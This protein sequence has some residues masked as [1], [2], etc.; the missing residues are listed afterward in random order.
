ELYFGNINPNEKQFVQ[1]S[2]YSK[3]MQTIFTNEGKLTELLTG[4]E[5]SLF[6]DYA[7]AQSEINSITAIEYFSDGFRL[8]AKIIL[9][10]MSDATGSLRNIR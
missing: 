9:E 10:V 7:N 1:N 3:A 5:K 8:G 4:K 2:G 6:F